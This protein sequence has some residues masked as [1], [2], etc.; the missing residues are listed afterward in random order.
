MTVQIFYKNQWIDISNNIDY[1]TPFYI[2]RRADEV[3]EKGS[4][5]AILDIKF[6]IP[7]FTIMNIDNSFYVCSSTSNK[8]LTYDNTYYHNFDVTEATII[9]NRY[10][11][12]SKAFSNT[13]TNK[14]DKEKLIVI[15]TLISRKYGVDFNLIQ[16]NFDKEQELQFGIGTTMFESFLEFTK[17]YNRVPKLKSISFSDTG[18]MTLNIDF[19]SL[20]NQTQ[21]ILDENKITSVQYHQNE[22]NYCKRVEGE[23]SDVV[24]RTNLIEVRD[25]T[26]RSNEIEVSFNTCRL[27]LPTRAEKVVSFGLEEER[28]KI[29]FSLRISES[30]ASAIGYDYST[31]SQIFKTYGE[32]AN[33]I[34]YD[35]NVRLLDQIYYEILEQYKIPKDYL[36]S[37]PF[38]AELIRGNGGDLGYFLVLPVYSEGSFHYVDGALFSIDLSDHII[39][40]EQYDL[41]ENKDKPDYCFYETNSNIIDGLLNYY[42]NDFWHTLVGGDIKSFIELALQLLPNEEDQHKTFPDGSRLDYG[43]KIDDTVYKNFSPMY[44]KFYAEYYAISDMPITSDKSIIPVNDIGFFDTSKLY[45]KSANFL[46]FDRIVES[47]QKVND[48]SGLPELTIEYNLASNEPPMPCQQI[49]YDGHTWYV[50]S[51]LTYFELNRKYCVINLVENYNKVA[52]AVSVL[53]QT[54]TVKNPLTN[55]ITRPILIDFTNAWIDNIDPLWFRMSFYWNQWEGV[56]LYKRAIV[57][58]SGDVMELFVEAL[59]QYCFDKKAVKVGNKFEKRASQ[60][61]AYVNSYNEFEDCRIEIVTMPRLSVEDSY[62]LPE[63]DPEVIN[64]STLLSLPRIKVFKD[65]REK[66]TFTVR[67]TKPKQ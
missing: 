36:Y 48:M 14:K 22:D 64:Y 50:E 27:E 57:M 52:D 32:F 31:N 49:T 26:M 20:E 15:S 5:N 28:T 63:Y 16:N 7:P 10:I 8:Y 35:G 58:Q 45:D 12:G 13:G 6:N 54:N 29:R 62:Q 25:L 19:Y 53:S 2:E 65:A 46:D 40:K 60:D 33:D 9:L 59:D 47:I 61:V 34:I 67:L 1:S 44:F 38:Y 43:V 56:T 24:D 39:S 41:L 23:L 37:L 51:I 55:I 21:Y 30:Y 3:F 11:L 42:N 17:A 18:K 66:L 4:F